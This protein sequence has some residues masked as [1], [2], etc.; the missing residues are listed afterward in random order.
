MKMQMLNTGEKIRDKFVIRGGYRI[1]AKGHIYEQRNVALT[2][3]NGGA[4][5]HQFSSFDAM[6]QTIAEKAF[7][8]RFL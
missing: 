2:E 6:L 1:I 8:I 7:Q 3:R 5:S 4:I